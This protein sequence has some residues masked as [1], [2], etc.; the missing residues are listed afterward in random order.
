MLE[1]ARSVAASLYAC[2]PVYLRIL[3]YMV[4][5]DSGWVS[6]EHL[7]LSWYP[8]H[9][10]I[11]TGSGMVSFCSSL[12]HRVFSACPPTIRTVDYDPFIKSQL[13]SC[14]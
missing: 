12:E 13:T 7:L 11:T 3:V 5:Y 6:L 1:G 14:D 2:G 10:L 4:I 9:E 8:S